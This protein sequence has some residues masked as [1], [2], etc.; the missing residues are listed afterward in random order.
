MLRP[1]YGSGRSPE[2]TLQPPVPGLYDL[3][4]MS[5]R[6]MSLRV[7]QPLRS[8]SAHAWPNWSREYPV[9]GAR[10]LTGNSASA[11]AAV[12]RL[13]APAVAAL[14]TFGAL[15]TVVAVGVSVS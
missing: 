9:F 11:A 2:V 6:K 12:P 13:A 4:T 5:R 10:P 1:V 7:S 3:L 8:T 15:V 14:A